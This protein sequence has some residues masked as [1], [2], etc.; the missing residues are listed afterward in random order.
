MKKTIAQ[1]K[2]CVIS[3]LVKKL[4]D[5]KKQ[6]EAADPKPL[7][8]VTRPAKLTEQIDYLKRTGNVDLATK[9]LVEQ[10]SAQQILTNPL[11]SN[12]E[13]ALAQLTVFKTVAAR[14][15]LI[16][17]KYNLDETEVDWRKAIGEIGKKKQKKTLKEAY[18][19]RKA[20]QKE[21]TDKVKE[22]EK[23]RSEWL[24]ENLDGETTTKNDDDDDDESGSDKDISSKEGDEESSV[25]SSDDTNAGETDPDVEPKTKK[26][27]EKKPVQPKPAKSTIKP[28]AKP[29]PEPAPKTH[30]PL[31]EAPKAPRLQL[32]SFFVTSGGSAYLASGVE[33][34]HQPL[35]PNDG[36]DRRERR[37]QQFGKAAPRASRPT[38]RLAVQSEHQQRQ[39]QQQRGRPSNEGGAFVAKSGSNPAADSNSALHPSWAAKQRT[40]G[41]ASFQG[42]K[43]TFGDDDGNAV[44]TAPPPAKRPNLT[45]PTTTADA[46]TDSAAA[47]LHPSWLAKQKL[48]PVISAFQG[49]KIT[50]GD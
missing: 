41:I 6:L 39:P 9:C 50:F 49:K 17:T 29:K 42:S 36:M 21:R 11:A 31:P 16:K 20:E 15:A 35:G 26:K 33:Q 30:V 5:A 44:E 43:K 1:A 37:A 40:K 14:V 23:K 46:S 4:R 22:A 18:L 25:E 47:K 45:V 19:K 48:K 10:R 2:V 12:D 28:A 34:R 7:K 32:D 27:P 38:P 13:V 24:E 3:K 8:L